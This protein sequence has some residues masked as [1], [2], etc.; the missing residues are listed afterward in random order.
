[1]PVRNSK[2]S[3]RLLAILAFGAIRLDGFAQ[4]AWT[5]PA[6][7][8]AISLN[9]ENFY[10]RDHL[11]QHGEAAELGT[12]RTNAVLLG[13]T[14]GVTDKLAAT[15][16]LPY[17]YS[18]YDGTFPHQLPIDNG[19]YHG[20]FVDYRFDDRYNLLRDAVVVTPFASAIVPSHH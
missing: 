4:E 18:H 13:V 7:E 3:L 15:I 17:A 20:T 11:A 14:Y 19:D 1:M 9:Y 5:P 2:L 10:V 16:S 8:A 12:V 6:G